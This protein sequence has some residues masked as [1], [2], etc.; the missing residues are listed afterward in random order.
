V[1]GKTLSVVL[2][3]GVAAGFKLADPTHRLATAVLERVGL[4]VP[5]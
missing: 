5:D 3:Y 4:E 2:L 1:V